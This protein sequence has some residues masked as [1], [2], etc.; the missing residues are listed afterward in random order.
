MEHEHDRRTGIVEKGKEKDTYKEETGLG[1]LGSTQSARN[2]LSTR[3][4]DRSSTFQLDLRGKRGSHSPS[5]IPPS[6]RRQSMGIS[7]DSIDV[8]ASL[9]PS[10]GPVVKLTGE[11]LHDYSSESENENENENE[12]E[13]G[14]GNDG[15]DEATLLGYSSPQKSHDHVDGSLSGD[16]NTRSSEI[17]A[18]MKKFTDRIHHE[19]MRM[20]AILEDVERTSKDER[21]KLLDSHEQMKLR[22]KEQL[23]TA[24]E[25]FQERIRLADEKVERLRLTLRQKTDEIKEL[26]LKIARKL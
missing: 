1:F 13:R 18:L 17:Q 8:R 9:I 22:M 16:E 4:R 11:I 21:D 5:K 15:V 26:K 23:L 25:G 2:R 20:K 14:Y 7:N 6:A 12:I 3:D 19:K 24:Q 10:Y